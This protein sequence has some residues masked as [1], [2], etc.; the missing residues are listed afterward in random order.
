MLDAARLRFQLHSNAC[1]ARYVSSVS[2]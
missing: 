2:S 1:I